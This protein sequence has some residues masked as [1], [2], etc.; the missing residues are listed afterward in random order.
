MKTAHSYLSDS[1]T[2][3]P[4]SEEHI[5]TYQGIDDRKRHPIVLFNDAIRQVR[6]Q[7]AGTKTLQDELQIAR[8]LA[9][10]LESV[11]KILHLPDDHFSVDTSGEA[12]AVSNSQGQH[13]I[14]P[15]HFEKGAYFS[16]PHFDHELN[17]SALQIPKIRIGKYVQFGIGSCINVGGD[18]S[19]GDYA[20]L[21]PGSVL[22]MCRVPPHLHRQTISCRRTLLATHRG[23]Q[24][25]RRD[26][27]G[28]LID[29]VEE[30]TAKYRI[31]EARR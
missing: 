2:V 27:L 24:R 26:R 23:K 1:I 25:S 7:S 30:K 5:P 18:L 14:L 20:W 21:A 6:Q 8:L 28:E 22:L 10:K 12:F 17:Y 4:I 13:Y 19:I 15:T 9:A 29:A 16:S 11:S 31:T 3:T